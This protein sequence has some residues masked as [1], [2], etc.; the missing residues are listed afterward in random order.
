[1]SSTS[2]NF[3]LA[4]RASQLAQIQTNIVLASLQELFPQNEGN[5]QPGP[6]FSTSFMSTAGDKNQSQALYLIGGKALWTKELEVALKEKDVDLLIHSL[7]DVPTTLPD[8]CYLG[9]ILEREDP[10]DSLVVKQGKPWKSLEDLPE[11]SVVGTSSVRRV[12]QMK[13]KFPHLKFMD[14]VGR[15][16]LNCVPLLNSSL[17]AETCVLILEILF[18]RPLD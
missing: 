14:V 16:S 12:A 17:S 11:G 8:G 4:S 7:K 5:A 10:V 1:M 9:A 2:R 15:S 18:N 13:R 3:V 6:T